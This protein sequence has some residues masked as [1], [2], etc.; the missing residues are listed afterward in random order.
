V[1]KSLYCVLFIA[2]V[3]ASF[4]LFSPQSVQAGVYVP[5]KD[6]RPAAG[7]WSWDNEN[8]TGTIIPQYQLAPTSDD[9]YA[10][11]QSEGVHLSGGT[12]LCHP[13]PGGQSGWTAEIRV[14]TSSG[15]HSVPTVNQ[16]VPD[17]EGKYMTCAQVWSSGTYAVF[18]YWVRPE[19]W[20]EGRMQCPVAGFGIIL[21][22][23]SEGVIFI[24]GEEGEIEYVAERCGPNGSIIFNPPLEDEFLISFISEVVYCCND[25]VYLTD[26]FFED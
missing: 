11:L 2:A 7:S 15:W 1:K 5:P 18:G 21:G 4:L 14:L 13:Y 9:D 3:V 23:V 16:W 20:N 22:P 6:T 8:V 26:S 24:E 17:K 19:G 25:T 12:Q 10:L